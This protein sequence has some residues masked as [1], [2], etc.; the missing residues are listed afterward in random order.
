MIVSVENDPPTNKAW[1]AT[2]I[3][4]LHVDG[5]WMA[6]VQ[7][8]YYDMICVVPAERILQWHGKM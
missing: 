5:Q 3:N 1:G 7:D 8:N 6:I 4:V 2:L